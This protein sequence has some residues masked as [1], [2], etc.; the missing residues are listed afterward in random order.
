MGTDTEGGGAGEGEQRRPREEARRGRRQ[1]MEFDSEQTMG[2]EA[3]GDRRREGERRDGGREGGRKGGRVKRHSPMSYI[4]HRL[5]S[6]ESEQ[7]APSIF[8]G[9][10]KK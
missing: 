8:P 6:K 5:H 10:I 7:R 4:L 3:R 1:T 2:R 9:E